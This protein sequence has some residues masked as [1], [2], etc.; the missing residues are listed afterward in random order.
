MT[1]WPDQR[2][3]QPPEVPPWGGAVSGPMSAGSAPPTPP[4]RAPV[5][6]SARATGRGWLVVAAVIVAM[7]LLGAG[8]LVGQ[9]ERNDQ[10]TG[11]G[12]L[13]AT[14]TSVAGSTTP[15]VPAAGDQPVV[16]VAERAQPRRRAD[17]D[18][19]GSWVGHHL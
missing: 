14:T 12:A 10:A 16:A 3:P 7:A 1:D 6:R 2:G 15:R 9:A 13:A 5:S 17:P 4:P 11:S 8:Y 18:P 19:R